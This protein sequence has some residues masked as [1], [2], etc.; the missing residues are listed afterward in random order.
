[1]DGQ[2]GSNETRNHV[3]ITALMAAADRFHSFLD[4]CHSTPFG[5]PMPQ[6]LLRG[7]I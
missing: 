2:Y 3:T 6:R 5:E 7:G 4:C 1:M